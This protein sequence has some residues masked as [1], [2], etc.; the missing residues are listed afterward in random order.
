MYNLKSLWLVRLTTNL[1]YSNNLTVLYLYVWR[2]Y[3]AVFPKP[4]HRMARCFFG[5]IVLVTCT[6]ALAAIQGVICRCYKLVAFQIRHF[7]CR[8]FNAK[9]INSRCIFLP[10]VRWCA[11]TSVSCNMSVLHVLY[12]KLA[13]FQTLVQILMRNLLLCAAFFSCVQFCVYQ[14]THKQKNASIILF[15]CPLCACYCLRMPILVLFKRSCLGE[16]VHMVVLQ[17]VQGMR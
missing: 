2:Q 13:A 12:G 11:N 5:T 14:C 6:T 15:T 3:L 1:T 16:Q 7:F 4:L 17:R 8:N 10:P 9:F